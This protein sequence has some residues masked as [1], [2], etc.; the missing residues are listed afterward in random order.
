VRGGSAS[1]GGLLWIEAA[2]GNGLELN[3][4]QKIR[5]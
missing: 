1:Y 5:K 3:V 2:E 4:L